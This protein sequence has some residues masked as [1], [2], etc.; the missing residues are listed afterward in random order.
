MTM[1]RK[2][3]SYSAAEY[4]EEN[5]FLYVNE[6]KETQWLLEHVHDFIEIVVVLDGKGIQYIDGQPMH[7]Q[8]GD[9]FALPIGVSH[10][11]RPS[12][13]KRAAPL[14]V[15]NIIIRSEWLEHLKVCLPDLSIKQM[16]DW[17]IGKGDHTDSLQRWAKA[18]DHLGA[19]RRISESMQDI[20]AKRDAA[21]LTQAMALVTELLVLL[22]RCSEWRFAPILAHISD[23]NKESL[24]LPPTRS[25]NRNVEQFLDYLTHAMPDDYTLPM[26][27]E[28]FQLSERQILRICHRHLG[29][30]YMRF[31]QKQ[32]IT[33]SC[34]L[35]ASPDLKIYEV[36]HASGFQN[37]DYFNRLFKRHTGLT[38][39]AYRKLLLH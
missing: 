6:V 23:A 30:S 32:R 26:L 1:P 38:P 20:L 34:R 37:A 3:G 15:R 8:E 9:V 35:L 28:K 39:S 27:T 31:V 17:L 19:I 5:G 14:I 13:A 18:T 10:V 16:I 7:V 36:M 4:I 33:H 2:L 12:P 24:P 29:T 21:Y 25:S 22:I 11:F